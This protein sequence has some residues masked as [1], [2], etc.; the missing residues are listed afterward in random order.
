M[1]GNAPEMGRTKE[2]PRHDHSPEQA[3]IYCR[4][5]D[6]SDYPKI[7]EK[8]WRSLGTGHQCLVT[9]LGSLPDIDLSGRP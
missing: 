4:E 6:L 7:C 1:S 5:G 8:C 2:K 3:C 9:C